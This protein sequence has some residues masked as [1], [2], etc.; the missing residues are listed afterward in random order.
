[1][2]LIN[3]DAGPVRRQGVGPSVGATRRGQS[4]GRPLRIASHTWPTKPPHRRRSRWR[5]THPAICARP[6]RARSERHTSQPGSTSSSMSRF[7][8]YDQQGSGW[9]KPPSRSVL[10][11][12]DYLDKSAL[13]S[14]SDADR[15]LFWH[16]LRTTIKLVP[17]PTLSRISQ[18]P[19]WPDSRGKLARLDE[20]CQPRHARSVQLLA[21]VL[22]Q[23]S[24]QLRKLVRTTKHRR[25]RIT[26]RSQPN[27]A[28][29]SRFLADRISAFP[30]TRPLT[31]DECRDF[32]K[33]E[34]DLGFLIRKSNAALRTDLSTL[35]DQYS[36][37]LA[38]DRRLK[39]PSGLVRMNFA[40]SHLHLRP[41]FLVERAEEI[42]EEVPGWGARQTP[43]AAQLLA[44]FR[45]D[46]ARLGAAL[47]RRGVFALFMGLFARGCVSPVLISGGQ[48][49]SQRVPASFRRPAEP[50]NGTEY[51]RSVPLGRAPFWTFA[52]R[53][54]TVPWAGGQTCDSCDDRIPG[55]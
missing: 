5:A 40:T 53:S 12:D 7:I 1:M 11:L 46:A 38:R 48:Q 19:V 13:A 17:A 28:E 24:T 36:I 33:F 51:R 42:L 29:L 31:L 27:Q 32:R 8:Q 16:W 4:P 15:K 14:A 50:R 20:L 22:R 26:T 44:T 6:T 10:T 52:R 34:R 23:P 49:P 3:L 2:K 54:G 35:A 41:R 39:A 21:G 9:P 25:T 18:L 30:R 43:S 55:T 47:L 45:D 37:A